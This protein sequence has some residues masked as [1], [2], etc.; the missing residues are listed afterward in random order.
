MSLPRSTVATIVSKYLK[1]GLSI[2]RE[3]GGD[4]CSKLSNDQKRTV[5]NWIDNDSTLTLKQFVA[6]VNQEM[7]ISVSAS[8][9]DRCI[10]TFHYSV[11]DTTIV[12]ERRNREST[13][14]ARFDYATKFSGLLLN[15]NDNQFVFLDE[16]GFSVST[17][18][19]RGRS[20]RG[21]SAYVTV[22]AVRTRNISVIASMN[23]YGMVDH[24][25]NDR[26][27]NGEDF[28]QYLSSLK[29][30]CLEKGI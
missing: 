24:V 27:V 8:T 2:P 6:K 25:V 1:D 20:L 15:R 22:P 12:P 9:I 14:E 29:I 28:K 10:D 3:R 11:K 23:K 21:T 30:K 13:I 17:R 5:L 4:T 16:V 7:G 19:K 18:P 26:P